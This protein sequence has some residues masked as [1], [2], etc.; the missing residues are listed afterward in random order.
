MFTLSCA[1]EGQGGQCLG[2][3]RPGGFL[4]FFLSFFLIYL[5]Y[6]F[7]INI[8]RHKQ[9]LREGLMENETPKYVK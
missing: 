4:S 7:N 1:T 5:D 6:Q 2:R 9:V 3:P 8:K